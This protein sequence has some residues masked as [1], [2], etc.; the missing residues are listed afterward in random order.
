[1]KSLAAFSPVLAL[2]ARL[3]FRAENGVL[4]VTF[5]D[6]VYKRK[7]KVQGAPGFGAPAKPVAPHL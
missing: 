3:R 6:K 2:T 5:G 7:V 4:F 1:M